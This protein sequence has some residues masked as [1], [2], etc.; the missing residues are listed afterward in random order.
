MR[1]LGHRRPERFQVAR[2]AEIEDH[3]LAL[4]VAVL[5]QSLAKPIDEWIRLGL[6][7]NP[8]DAMRGSALR[9][10]GGRTWHEDRGHS[11]EE[12]PSIE[13]HAGQYRRV[14]TRGREHGGRC[15]WTPHSLGPRDR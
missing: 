5:A 4:E 12:G 10:G 7:G 6:G 11:G 8:P 2:V 13:R 1:Q 14:L 15:H 9:L 3:I